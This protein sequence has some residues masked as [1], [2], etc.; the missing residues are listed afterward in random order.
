MALQSKAAESLE[1]EA[2]RTGKGAIVL[3]VGS[4]WCV[5]GEKVRKLFESAEF[6]E[7][8]GDK[9]VLGVYDEMENPT[10]EVLQ[11]N[12]RVKSLLV[13]TKCFPAMTLYS[14][15]MKIIGHM[16]VHYLPQENELEG[17]YRYP[18]LADESGRNIE[19]EF[20]KAAGAKGEEAADMYGQV[21][22]RLF[23]RKRDNQYNPY[24][25]EFTT[26]EHGWKAE[27][28]ALCKLDDGDK[29]GWL[30]HFRMDERETV[31]MV[32]KLTA[33]KRK[34]YEEAK[35]Y[36]RQVKAMPT[37]H[38]TPNQLQCIDIMDYALRIN[39]L[40]APLTAETKKLLQKVLALGG[41][42]F[43]GEFARGRLLLDGEKIVVPD[44]QKV[45]MVSRPK[46]SAERIP[47]M[48]EKSMAAIKDIKPNAKL[49]ERQKLEIARYAALRLI[50]KEGW[51]KL[52]SRPGSDKFVRAFLDDR[53][54][55]EDFAWNGLFPKA[56][57]HQ[58][59]SCEPGSGAGAIL[60][61]ES[62]VFQDKGR[63]VKFKDGKF[64][65]NEGRRFM[66]AL[67]MN[68][69]DQSEEW[70]AEILD[71]YR[72]TAQSGRLHKSAYSQPVWMWRMALNFHYFDNIAGQQ[73]FMDSLVNV[74]IKEYHKVSW[75]IP[76]NGIRYCF[77]GRWDMDQVWRKA[78]GA[79]LLR[80]ASVTGGGARQIS[81][82]GVACANAR[83]V[84]TSIVEQPQGALAYSYRQTDGSW[85]LGFNVMGPSQMHFCFWPHDKLRRPWQYVTAV[86]ST[87]GANREVRHAADRMLT[88]AK[89]AWESKRDFAAAEKY[90]RRACALH[91][92][93]YGAWLEY[94]SYLLGAN[95]SP[96][97]LGKYVNALVKG[98]KSGGQ[99]LWDLLT[100]YFKCVA[101]EQG[102]EVVK[103]E[104]MRLEPAIK[105]PPGRLAEEANFNAMRNRWE[106]SM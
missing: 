18:L 35:D 85:Q 61:L 40:D 94:E 88:L 17:M 7:K 45:K 36:L 16:D 27:W 72:A 104:I 95:A 99:P 102:A 77:G 33:L 79:P 5:S 65:D 38:F 15:S 59:E 19:A 62:L 56:G 52:V 57:G 9:F 41:D 28:E 8:V 34:S 93:H 48:L 26:G 39:G 12:E 10:R 54:W 37:G 53:T 92:G 82:F 29:Y 74:P 47:F 89:L 6:R 2:R 84:P 91:P 14:P 103:R 105:T 22:D 83:G 67:A 80:Y 55:L 60:A 69:P 42:T 51:Q 86:E 24:F 70:L 44:H 58:E 90:C 11:A 78:E 106:R 25:K 98:Y 66:T 64:E 97:E 73:R 4:D 101:K 43:W 96:E 23:W 32:A 31:K 46:K 21:F 13:R 1:E 81:G 100:P 63:W 87:F 75:D 76:H 30:A 3:Q 68:Q 49:G 71:A 20:K 50:G